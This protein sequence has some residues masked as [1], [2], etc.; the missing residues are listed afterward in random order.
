MYIHDYTDISS[1]AFNTQKVNDQ[2]EGAKFIILYQS[3]RYRE[4][5]YGN[6]SN[7]ERVKEPL[8]QSQQGELLAI[9]IS[10]ITHTT[11]ICIHCVWVIHDTMPNRV[12]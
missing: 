5:E 4:G 8:Q 10:D 6:G 9:A 3:T 7:I 1:L 2:P 12:L 11:R